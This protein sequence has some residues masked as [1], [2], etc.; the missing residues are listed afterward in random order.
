MTPSLSDCQSESDLGS[1]RKSCDVYFII[2][3][4]ENRRVRYV[5]FSSRCPT[6]VRQIEVWYYIEFNSIEWYT[7]VGKKWQLWGT[8]CPTSD[9]P[10][11]FPLGI[12]CSGARVTEEAWG[13]MFLCL[14]YHS[15]WVQAT[16]IHGAGFIRR[17]WKPANIFF[18]PQIYYGKSTTFNPEKF[19]QKEYKM[20]F[21]S[22]I[23]L[24]M[25]QKVLN[26]GP[27]RLEIDW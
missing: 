5:T 27:K 11:N 4:Q 10:L 8:Q 2:N 20:V 23:G 12:V 16:Y 13:I 26:N 17:E 15:R 6:L 9:T 14:L 18:H 1:I 24:E 7:S 21:L 22:R 25:D 3:H 19:H